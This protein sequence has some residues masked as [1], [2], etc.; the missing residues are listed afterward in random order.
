MPR[1]GSDSYESPYPSFSDE[2]IDAATRSSSA[3]A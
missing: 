1:G 3:E 2:L